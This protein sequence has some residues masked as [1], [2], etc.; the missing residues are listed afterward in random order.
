MALLIS[1]TVRRSAFAATPCVPA[2]LAAVSRALR[3]LPSLPDLI[4]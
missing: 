1:C 3:P 2:F 4:T